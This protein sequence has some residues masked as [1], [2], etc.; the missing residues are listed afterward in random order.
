MRSISVAVLGLLIAVVL[1]AAEPV[2]DYEALGRI[3]DEGFRRSEVMELA[4]HL[5]D[6]IG[7]RL[8]GSPQMK[9]ANDWTLAKLKEWGLTNPHL[10]PYE[11]GDGWTFSRSEVRQLA[12][13]PAV[14]SAFPKAWTPGTNGAV[15]GMALRAKIET[16]EDFDKLA[17]KLSGKI[18]FLSDP[19]EHKDP[20]DSGFKRWDEVK[21]AELADYDVPPLRDPEARRERRRKQRELWKKIADRLVEEGVVATVETSSFEHGVV[22]L[23]GHAFQGVPG[24]PVGPPQLGMAMEPYERILRLLDDDREV[25]LEL[26]IET[27]FHRDTTQAWN[28]L[29]E[30]PGTGKTGEVVMVGAHLDSWHLGTGATDNA[31]GS[32]VILEALRI[33]EAIGAKPKRTIRL[34]LW[35]G[36]EQGLLGSKAY[37]EAHFAARPEPTDP[38]ELAQPKRW[39]RATW[40]LQPKPDHR[41]LALYLNMDNGGGRVRGIYAQENLG[42][43]AKFERWIAPLAD[44]GVTTVTMENTASTDHDSFDRAGLPGFQLVQD[45]RDYSYRTHHSNLDTYER[46]NREDLMQASVVM[47]SLLYQAAMD[48]APFPRKPLPQEP[49]KRPAKDKKDEGEK[50]IEE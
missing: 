18:L 15:R 19:P 29:A 21:L 20:A 12:P 14:L 39:R 11:F 44:L 26:S 7:Q 9:A 2:P 38:E 28:T 4:R 50:G 47:A 30:L 8:T 13:A 16:V 37:V 17:G 22:R 34:A 3:R 40:P 36:E 23:G 24:L 42:A 33:L 43:R 25:E 46:L 35:S 5:C 32:A 48:E 49:A 41:K 27:Q 31:A 45:G 1:P 6:V 10:E